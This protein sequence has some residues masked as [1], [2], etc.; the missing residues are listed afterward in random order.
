[1]NG[2]DFTVKIGIRT[3]DGHVI[4]KNESKSRLE[5]HEELRDFLDAFVKYMNIETNGYYK[6]LVDSVIVTMSKNDL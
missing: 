6:V 4:F 2:L 3:Y 5:Q 1:M